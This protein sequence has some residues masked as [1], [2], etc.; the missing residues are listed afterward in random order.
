M[1]CPRC[2]HENRPQA[3]FCEECASPFNRTSPTAQTCADPKGEV[4]SL[5]Q[6]LTEAL[7]QQTA[8]SG[9]LR[10]ISNSPTDIEPVLDTI[11]QDGLRLCEAQF[12]AI[13]RF[14]GEAF[15]LA[16]ASEVAP[17][18]RAYLEAARIRPGRETPLR[19][20]ALEKRPVQVADVL[21]D[22]DSAPPEIYRREGMRTALSVPM[23]KEGEL[24]GALTFHRREVRPFSDGQI[25][26]LQTFADQAVIAIENV[27]LFS[28]TKEALEQQ[29]AT[30]EILRV[31]S[32]S[33]TD[34]Q[35]VFDA[36]AANAARLCGVDDVTIHRVEDGGLRRVAH[37]GSVP[38]LADSRLS[39]LPG[40]VNERVLSER[41][42]VHVPDTHAPSFVGQFP[43]SQHAAMGI[44][45]LLATPLVRDGV[46]IGLI[47]LRR[48]EP[49]PFTDKQIALLETFADQAVIAIENARLFDETKEALDQQT[50]TTEILRVISSSPTD[51]QPVFDAIA[52]KALGLCRATIGWVYRFD[53]EL[54]HFAAAHSLTP[55]GIEIRRQSYPLLLAGWSDL[56]RD[57]E[58]P[59]STFRTSA[60]IPSTG[61]RPRQGCRHL[62]V[63]SVP[64]LR[65]GKT[66]GVI[67]VAGPEA[68][69]F[70]E[71]QI[72][73]LQTFA[74]QAVIAIENVRLFKELQE[75]TREL[76]R[77]VE[78]L[79]ALA[80][81]AR[82]VS[83][84]LDLPNGARHDRG[85][86][87]G[88]VRGAGRVSSTSTTRRPRTF[89]LRASHRMEAELVEV[90]H[91]GTD[92]AGGG[93]DGPG[94]DCGRAGPGARH[95]GGAGV[96]FEPAPVGA[97]CGSAI[98]RAWSFRS[99]SSSGSWA[100]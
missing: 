1:Q 79:R 70:S 44:R 55:E 95:R 100:P 73:L 11:L 90:L 91:G 22:P 62:S 27:R 67:T 66:I 94:G 50:A 68:G 84:T 35:P 18:F 56:A 51:I 7:E 8:T 49:R 98:A 6:A 34:V 54:I 82:A 14:H 13:F 20:V 97:R 81:S 40:G 93:C 41:R 19:R 83:S 96:P 57:S 38:V 88:A 12:G 29:T 59:W 37:V 28:E 75:R 53:G 65:E 69:A 46:V 24:V 9:I 99:W 16:V 23:L 63:L 36:V 26:L 74:D 15:R 42:T 47:Q 4:E 77:S 2:Q 87:R 10:A 60:R 17:E 45:S 78:E 92:R 21:D 76:A 3:K 48:S 52:D 80:R 71:K 30:S 89:H 43:G 32:G 39:L 58:P 5:R 85:P 64:M 61:S 72:A 31:I 33:P 25:A 86:R